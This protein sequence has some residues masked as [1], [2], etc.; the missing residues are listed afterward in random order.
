M[1]PEILSVECK[2]SS[3]IFERTNNMKK[4]VYTSFLFTL[5]FCVTA[6]ST[7]ADKAYVTDFFRITLRTGPSV[8]NKI[9]AMLPSGRSFEILETQD[10][11]RHIRVLEGREKDL[12][13]WILNRYVITRVPWEAQA[14]YFKNENATLKKRLSDTEKQLNELMRKEE[15]VSKNLKV[16]TNALQK[17]REDHD[18]LKQGASGYLE[19][20]S[21]YEAMESTLRSNQN[22]VQKLTIE[23]E[24]L[25]SSS[26]N[27]W[28]ASGAI[29]LLIG[30]VIGLIMGSRQKKRKSMLYP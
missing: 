13:G 4:I 28:F 20:K 5:L 3:R 8:D 11:W 17:L 23:N 7:W 16:N 22:T 27:T 15:E 24:K 2:E 19:L 1:R 12:E 25:K 26:R 6:S 18:S 14:T 29:V 30:L 9:I 10:D 21:K